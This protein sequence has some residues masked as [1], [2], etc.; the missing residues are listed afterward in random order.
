MSLK[1][2]SRKLR[3]ELARRAV[4]NKPQIEECIVLYAGEQIPEGTPETT[5]VVH[6]TTPRMIKVAQDGS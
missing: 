3:T 6:T 2:L 5:Y 1:L 4:I